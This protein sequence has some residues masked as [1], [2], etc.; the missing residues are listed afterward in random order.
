VAL[1]PST[2]DD[3][4]DMPAGSGE[5]GKVVRPRARSAVGVTGP[6]GTRTERDRPAASRTVAD[7]RPARRVTRAGL[8]AGATT[9]TWCESVTT[10]RVPSGAGASSVKRVGSTRAVPPG[11]VTLQASPSLRTI[12]TPR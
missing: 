6:P 4:G 3:G 5:V 9:V 12:C 2:A 1:S 10:K 8:P 7:Q 11:W